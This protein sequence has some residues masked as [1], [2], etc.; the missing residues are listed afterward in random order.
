MLAA[1][2]LGG[3]GMATTGKLHSV[4]QYL[5]IKLTDVQVRSLAAQCLG[6]GRCEVQLGS[7]LSSAAPAVERSSR[8]H[9]PPLG[10]LLLRLRL[11]LLGG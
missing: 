3:A 10:V 6:H 11:V 8:P 5:N 4:D 1:R 9:C 2:S 7:T